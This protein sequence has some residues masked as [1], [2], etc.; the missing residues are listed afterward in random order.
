MPAKYV[1]KENYATA[2]AFITAVYDTVPTAAKR[3]KQ[4]PLGELYMFNDNVLKVITANTGVATSG[5]VFTS[6]GAQT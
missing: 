2:A 6:V 5:I 4:F 1:I 3:I